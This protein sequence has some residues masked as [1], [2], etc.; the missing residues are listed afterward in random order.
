MPESQRELKVETT[1]E[2]RENESRSVRDVLNE[3]NCDESSENAAA[4]ACWDAAESCLV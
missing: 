3:T 1:A 4:E 2:S